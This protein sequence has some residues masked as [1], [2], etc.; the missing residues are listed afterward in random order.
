M[1]GSENEFSLIKLKSLQKSSIYHSEALPT[2]A[3]YVLLEFT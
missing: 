1:I 2:S 3:V